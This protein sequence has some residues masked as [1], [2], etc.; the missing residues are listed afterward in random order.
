MSELLVCQNCKSIKAS[1]IILENLK[2]LS[3]EL[4]NFAI[5]L[6]SIKVSRRIKPFNY[7][8]SIER[9]VPANVDF[10]YYF[11]SLLLPFAAVL[12]A[13]VELPQSLIQKERKTKEQKENYR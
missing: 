7:S 9:I 2:E 11:H 1:K 12:I 10:H 8:G 4:W 6:L 13:A 3:N 5:L